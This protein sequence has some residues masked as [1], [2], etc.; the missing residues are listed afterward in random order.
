MARLVERSYLSLLLE[1]DPDF[2]STSRNTNRVEYRFSDGR[3][4]M[5]RDLYGNYAPY[6][7]G[8]VYGETIVFYNGEMVTYTTPVLLNY[9]ETET[10]GLIATFEG[11]DVYYLA[12]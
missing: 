11:R 7:Y 5:G 6:E 3:E 4:F 8:V 2:Y 10:Y 9:G 1:A 12:G